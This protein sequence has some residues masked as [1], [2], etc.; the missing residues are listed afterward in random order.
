[1]NKFTKNQTLL[2][3]LV[4]ITLCGCAPYQNVQQAYVP[5]PNIY[6]RSAE[7][8]KLTLGAVQATVKKKALVEMKLFL[9]LVH[10]T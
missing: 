6:S 5:Q 8:N 4:P 2:F 1:M 9:N 7:A 3:F 10:P